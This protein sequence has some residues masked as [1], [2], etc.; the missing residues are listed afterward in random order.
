[1]VNGLPRST[2]WISK[3]ISSDPNSQPP[4]SLPGRREQLRWSPG[5]E[6]SCSAKKINEKEHIM[7]DLHLKT[8]VS[9]CELITMLFGC[10][11]RLLQKLWRKI[12][13]DGPQPW[14][15]ENG[16]SDFADPTI[17]APFFESSITPPF[18]DGRPFMIY[19]AILFWQGIVDLKW[20]RHRFSGR[21]PCSYELSP[22]TSVVTPL[23]S[24]GSIPTI[25][26]LWPD[27]IPCVAAS[28]P[29]KDDNKTAGNKTGIIGPGAL[30]A[31]DA[32][33]ALGPD[34]KN[35]LWLSMLQAWGSDATPTGLQ[36]AGL[37]MSGVGILQDHGVTVM[38]TDGNS[39][40][41]IFPTLSVGSHRNF[42]WFKQQTTGWNEWFSTLWF[43]FTILTNGITIPIIF[44]E[45]S[46]IIL[47]C[48]WL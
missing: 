24:Y 37:K 31:L 5:A 8:A 12:P 47:V 15:K 18:T 33:D 13:L 4:L 14:E 6:S 34:A 11:H 3:W 48:Q 46:L 29:G 27:L 39:T 26:N 38:A 43:L 10:V 40:W 25:D 9:F 19:D 2:F 41:S 1:M 36:V 35:C 23:Q 44:Q 28:L 21:N 30:D 7:L 42:M 22:T 20:S 16:N 17:G 32:L 45:L